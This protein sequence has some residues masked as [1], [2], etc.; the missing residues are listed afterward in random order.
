MTL[1]FLRTPCLRIH[2]QRKMQIDVYFHF[3]FFV[4]DQKSGARENREELMKKLQQ[5]E[6]QNLASLCILVSRNTF[7]KTNLC[8]RFIVTHMYFG[9]R[10][11]PVFCACQNRTKYNHICCQVWYGGYWK[12]LVYI[13]DTMSSRCTS[14]NLVPTIAKGD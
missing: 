14:C 7:K 12:Y 6:L 13:L 4:I 9:C 10:G 1:W 5:I 3:F 8:L 11:N 2:Q